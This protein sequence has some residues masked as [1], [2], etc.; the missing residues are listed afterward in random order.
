[1]KSLYRSVSIVSDLSDTLYIHGVHLSFNNEFT[2]PFYCTPPSRFIVLNPVN[3][4]DY[5]V[6]V[7]LHAE[8]V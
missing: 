4:R 5:C 1:M 3:G 8:A 2:G 6:G 7:K